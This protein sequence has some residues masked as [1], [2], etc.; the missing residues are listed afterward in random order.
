[1]TKLLFL[2]SNPSSTVIWNHAHTHKDWHT[3]LLR[4]NMHCNTADNTYKEY[5][6]KKEVMIIK[7]PRP[8]IVLPLY[9]T[10]PPLLFM[11]AVPPN[12]QRGTLLFC[13]LMINGSASHL[14]QC[15]RLLCQPPTLFH[16]SEGGHCWAPFWT[17]SGHPYCNL[18]PLRKATPCPLV[19]V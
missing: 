3:S 9:E 17:Q 12:R 7:K 14:H 6:D 11:L 2:P 5:L 13:Q 1:M 8:T 19:S 4:K 15:P 10:P 18:S 16:C